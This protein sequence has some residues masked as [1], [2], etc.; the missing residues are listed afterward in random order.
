VARKRTLIVVELA[1]DLASDMD[2]TIA[3]LRRLHACNPVAFAQVT[4]AAHAFVAAY[5]RPGEPE[6]V[7]QAR[8]ARIRS[9][10]AWRGEA[11]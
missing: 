7:F 1:P 6:A 10:G 9:P 2:E 11:N 8:L 3:A 4:A 5:E